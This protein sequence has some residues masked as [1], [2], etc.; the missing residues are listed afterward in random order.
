MKSLPFVTLTLL[1]FSSF[2]MAAADSNRDSDSNFSKAPIY[3]KEWSRYTT[4]IDQVKT[5][6]N[7]SYDR[8]QKIKRRLEE[9][10]KSGN[11]TIYKPKLPEKKLLAYIYN[12]EI[13]RL[14]EIITKSEKSKESQEDITRYQVIR[15]IVYELIEQEIAARKTNTDNSA[16][17]THK[18][19]SPSKII[20]Q[21]SDK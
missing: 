15:G 14:N 10:I 20:E 3:G 5:H 16:S 17:K 2:I 8:Y 13:E 21:S 1:L 12:D 4:L 7:D 18:G 19:K 11:T 9:V 6:G